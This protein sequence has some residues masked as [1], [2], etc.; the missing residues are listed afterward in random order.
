V[1]E[2]TVGHNEIPQ[3][4]YTLEEYDNGSGTHGSLYEIPQIFK[5]PDAHIQGGVEFSAFADD[6]NP[7]GDEFSTLVADNNIGGHDDTEGKSKVLFSCTYDISFAA[8]NETKPIQ[9]KSNF[10][11]HAARPPRKPRPPTKGTHLEKM[12]KAMKRRLPILVDE[13]KK[14]PNDP[15]QAAKFAS[16]CGVIIR[17]KMPILTHW[18]KYKKD[19]KLYEKFASKLSVSS[20]IF[21]CLTCIPA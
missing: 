21:P 8:Y 9:W 10:V 6:D 4:S 1:E 17:D 20:L 19:K 2:P 3:R 7:A 13:G 15:V 5:D 16:E 18:K 11:A 12:T 14:R